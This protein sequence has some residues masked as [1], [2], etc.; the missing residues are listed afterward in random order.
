MI[1]LM[2]YA[3]PNIDDVK[4][5]KTEKPR[6]EAWNWATSNT[7]ESRMILAVESDEDLKDK[8]G[9]LLV[10]LFN[11][12]RPEGIQ[13]IKK[14]ENLEMA[15]KRVF[16]RM[17]EV[18]VLADDAP[19]VQDPPVVET[20]ETEEA[21]M[22]TKKKAAKKTKKGGV[23]PQ[24]KYGADDKI[25][26]KVDANPRREGTKAWKAFEIYKEGMKVSTFLEKGGTTKDLWWDV[27]DGNI[28]IVKA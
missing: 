5:F 4:V 14:F 13:P 28:K 15:R 24:S 18:A 11:E 16:S 2:T 21:D 17:K 6:Q 3:C 26:I 25:S 10:K 1:Y 23:A 22:A 8:S 20:P 12:M 19:P 27:R 9:S 7:S